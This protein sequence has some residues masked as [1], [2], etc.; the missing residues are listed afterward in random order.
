[1]MNFTHNLLNNIAKAVNGSTIIRGKNNKGEPVDI[2][3]S[4]KWK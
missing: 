3:L 1:M 2:D 4:Q